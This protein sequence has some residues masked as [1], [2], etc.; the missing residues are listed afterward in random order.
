MSLVDVSCRDCKYFYEGFDLSGP[1]DLC[2]FYL[3]SGIHR[4]CPAGE[5][6]ARHLKSKGSESKR[7]RMLQRAIYAD[8]MRMRE[9]RS[10]KRG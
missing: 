6:C 7:K 9:R 5:G 2:E 3:L 8:V 4:G 1:V 10:E